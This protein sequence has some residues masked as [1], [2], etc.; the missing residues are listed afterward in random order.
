MYK[1]RSNSPSS[2]PYRNSRLYLKIN[3]SENMG[4]NVVEQQKND[5]FDAVNS[6]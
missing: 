1:N 5:T 4:Q 3:N 6:R 2:K